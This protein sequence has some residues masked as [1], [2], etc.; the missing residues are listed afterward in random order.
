MTTPNDRTHLLAILILTPLRSTPLA[1]ALNASH[2][3][4]DFL[5]GKI[6]PLCRRRRLLPIETDASSLETDTFLLETDF[7]FLE[8]DAFPLETD[9]FLIVTDARNRMK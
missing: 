9:A 1:M 3:K 6:R 4:A 7:F 2:I 8:T 5:C